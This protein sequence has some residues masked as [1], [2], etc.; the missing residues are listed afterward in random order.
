MAESL[1]ALRLNGLLTVTGVVGGLRGGDQVPDVMSALWNL[2]IVRGIY[3]GSHSMFRD[4]V[5][6]L[7][8]NEVRPA[9]DDVTFS[10]EEAK[11]AFERLERQAHFSKVVIK[12]S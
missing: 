6:F 11:S 4:M 2:C 9:L 10:L 8:Q 3:L 7:E 12:M 1:K 5:Q